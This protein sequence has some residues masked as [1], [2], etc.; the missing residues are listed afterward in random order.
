MSDKAESFFVEHSR[1]L[2]IAVVVVLPL[3]LVLSLVWKESR[4]R[5]DAIQTSRAQIT[6]TSCLEQNDRHDATVQ[7]LDLLLTNRKAK[8][9]EQI[10]TAE[11]R[12][13]IARVTNLRAQLDALD[14]TRATTVSLIDALAPL[15]GCEQL[16]LDRFGE[17]PEIPL[18]KENP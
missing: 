9:R 6:Y 11:M 10:V 2:T 12:G 3:L 15:R 14:D 16:V 13:D 8:V 17:V 18:P 4:D 5:I 7:Q 1:T